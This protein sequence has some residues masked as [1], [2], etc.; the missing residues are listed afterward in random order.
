[1]PHLQA[2]RRSPKTV[3]VGPADTVIIEPGQRTTIK[4]YV[5]KER[6]APVRVKERISVGAAL[7]ADVE[8]RTV[9][10]AWGP[11]LSKYRYVYADDHIYLVEPSNR[12]VVQVIE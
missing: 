9:P 10:S 3:G 5:L 7:P 2:H 1:L 4:E 8:L 6:V 12:T 11:R